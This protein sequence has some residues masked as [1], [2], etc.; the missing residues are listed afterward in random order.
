MLPL[1]VYQPGFV[2]HCPQRGPDPA[3]RQS[4]VLYIPP[5]CAALR[6]RRK[7]SREVKTATEPSPVLQIGN[8]Q[9]RP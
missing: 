5:R 4:L 3:L 8:R 1:S 9:P 6:V 2:L 7:P